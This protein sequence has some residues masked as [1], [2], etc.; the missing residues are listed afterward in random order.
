MTKSTKRRLYSRKGLHS[1]KTKHRNNQFHQNG[2]RV[3]SKRRKYHKGGMENGW[4]SSEL[5]NS[6]DYGNSLDNLTDTT[7]PSDYGNKTNP[8]VAKKTK[9]P[10]IDSTNF[11][12]EPKKIL[13]EMKKLRDKLP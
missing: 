2:H 13:A 8:T 1:R 5:G 12:F 4:L 7:N 11:F 10:P 3:C 9:L 6:S